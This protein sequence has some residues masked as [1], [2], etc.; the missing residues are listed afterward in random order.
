MISGIHFTP[1]S[2]FGCTC[3]INFSRKWIT[4]TVKK[5][6]W[7]RKW[8]M[9][10]FYL[11]IISELID[12]QRERERK[13]KKREQGEWTRSR[14]NPRC[15]GKIAPSRSRCQDRAGE[16]VP[17]RSRRWDHPAEIVPSSFGLDLRR[18]DR[19]VEIAPLIFEPGLIVVVAL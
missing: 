8:F 4:L 5:G 13:S 2:M 3:K 17:L 15:V 9:F 18:R 12:T 14:P 10:S 6:L 11:Q 7:P 16:I 1:S 19:P